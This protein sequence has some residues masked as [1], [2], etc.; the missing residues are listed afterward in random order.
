MSVGEV[1]SFESDTPV[2]G[3]ASHES[4]EY[5]RDVELTEKL[6]LL[7]DTLDAHRSPDAVS[8]SF[9]FYGDNLE[10]ACWPSVINSLYGDYG[11][12]D[13]VEVCCNHL[14]GGDGTSLLVIF[15]LCSDATGDTTYVKLDRPYNYALNEW[16]HDTIYR[17][18]PDEDEFQKTIS[19]VS[20]KELNRCLAGLI[21]GDPDINIAAFDT[22]SWTDKSFEKLVDDFKESSNDYSGEHEFLFTDHEGGPAGSLA[23]QDSDGEVVDVEVYRV[24][25][26]HIDVSAGGNLGYYEKAIE[27]SIDPSDPTDPPLFCEHHY[28]DDEKTLYVL[29]RD[30]FDYETAFSFINQQIAACD[31]LPLN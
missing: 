15:G 23:Y 31:P 17:D 19:P 28:V 20:E 9:K 24:V 27:V 14:D 1:P 25:K 10:G 16:S 12:V 29:D 3:V 2:T 8:Y 22:F 5:L 30:D 4:G 18:D 13:S 7:K 21:Y 11:Q 6:L 26:Q